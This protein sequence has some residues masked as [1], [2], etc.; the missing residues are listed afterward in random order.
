MSGYRKYV[1][2][3]VLFFLIYKLIDLFSLRGVVKYTLDNSV[4]W[5]SSSVWTEIPYCGKI[6]TKAFGK[7]ADIEEKRNKMVIGVQEVS[8]F[9]NKYYSQKYR[10]S[11]S[12]PTDWYINVIVE[13]EDIETVVLRKKGFDYS[14]TSYDGPEIN[15]GSPLMFSTSGALCA[16]RGCEYS[17]NEATLFDK[18]IQIVKGYSTIY[19]ESGF[20]VDTKVDFYKFS[21]KF[22]ETPHEKY[23]RMEK[24]YILSH[25]TSEMHGN[26]ILE[27]ISTLDIK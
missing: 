15:F 22:L 3:L 24:L 11:F 7:L 2:I 14:K 26:E 23:E 4:C 8:A 5:E 17:G 19:N 12:Y 1:L 21:H 10:Y 18:K 13:M 27:I 20:P 9:D 6:R 25:F 16:N